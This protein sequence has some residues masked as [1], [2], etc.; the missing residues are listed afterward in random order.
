VPFYNHH[1]TKN[2][3]AMICRILDALYAH[4][5]S[6]IIAF[7]TNG[8]NMMTG[9]HAGVVTLIDHESKTKLMRIWCA[10][11]QIDLVMK[12]VSYSLDDGLFY[13]IAHDFS[14]HLRCQQNL[15]LEMGST[16]PK[17]TNRWVHLEHMLSWMLEHCCRLLIWIDEKKPASAPNDS[18]WL[19][20][21]GVRPLLKLINVT[22]VIL[23]SPNIIFSQQTSKIENLIGHLASTMNME[24]VGT[25]DAFE[26]MH[27]SFRI[28]C[29][30][31][32]VGKNQGCLAPF[33]QPMI[34]G[35]RYVSG[36]GCS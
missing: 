14:V 25:N 18:W 30:G 33:P 19:M 10:L 5:Q 2:I 36:F 26:A 8:K 35:P 28:H 7:N 24:L 23:Q 20:T 6:K 21:A 4:W 31:S 12:D 34:V 22:L 16:C 13:K 11:H 29:C 15:Q 27:A 9:R 32:L 17:D 3:A 1:T